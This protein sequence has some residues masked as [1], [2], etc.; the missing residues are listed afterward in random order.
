M[1]DIIPGCCERTNFISLLVALHVIVKCV[2]IFD[3][4]C[5]YTKTKTAKKRDYSSHA[6]NFE[7]EEDKVGK[8]EK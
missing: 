8:G 5:V 4:V 1:C 2:N 6:K 7:V 3:Q